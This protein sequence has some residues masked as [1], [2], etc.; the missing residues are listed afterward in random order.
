MDSMDKTKFVNLIWLILEY[1]RA[2]LIWNTYPVFFFFRIGEGVRYTWLVELKYENLR[3]DSGYFSPEQVSDFDLLNWTKTTVYTFFLLVHVFVF[4]T[5][6]LIPDAAFRL[7]CVLCV[8][9]CVAYLLFALHNFCCRMYLIFPIIFSSFRRIA[10][11]A[12]ARANIIIICYFLF[13]DL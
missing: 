5:Y 13:T 3:I 7:Q 9:V 6:T 2:L 8:C 11:R 12:S 10:S 4:C 1:L